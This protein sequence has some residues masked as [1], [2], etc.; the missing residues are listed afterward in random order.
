[1]TTTTNLTALQRLKL[2]GMSGAYQ[3]I[4]DLP[5]DQHPDDHELLARLLNAEA[6]AY[7]SRC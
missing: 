3:G 4:L 6:Q 2:T 7:Q 5:L 1:M